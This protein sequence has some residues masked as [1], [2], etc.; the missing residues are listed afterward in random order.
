[1]QPT[2]LP[3]F[4]RAPG[5]ASLT[6]T[7]RDRH[8]LRLV[9]RHRFLPSNHI[10]ALVGNNAQPVLRR[11]QRLYHNGYLERPRA[12]L[13]YYLEGGS[14]R[15]VYGLGKKGL[16]LIQQEAGVIASG[17]SLAENNRSAGR[18]FLA[19]ALLVSDVMVALELA[20]R[21]HSRVRLIHQD[22]LEATGKRKPFRWWVKINGHL[23]LG[24][25]PDQVFALEYPDANNSVCRSYFFL[26]A[27]RGTMPVVRRQLS[28]TS[29]LRKLIAYEATWTQNLHRTRFGLHRFRVLTVTTS[30]KRVETMIKS[31]ST[32]KRGHGLFL[33][34]DSTV[35]ES[36]KNLLSAVWQS[37]AL[38]RPS[39]LLD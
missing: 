2:R 39:S 27:D 13:N 38:S 32:L 24:V 14:H 23:K 20:C 16:A 21:T 15:M 17:D 34:A 28:Q 3:R 1:M 10:I 4:Q 18:L 25:V 26:E 35:L 29:F 31:C 30:A 22:E 7:E 8:I 36:P 5:T 6:L 12:Q 33:F 37:V 11:L 19:H 9:H